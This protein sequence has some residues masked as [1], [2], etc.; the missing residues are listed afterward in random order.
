MPLFI[1][2]KNVFLPINDFQLIVFENAN[3]M[4]VD[5]FMLVDS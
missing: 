5:N 3:G 1:R 4:F 2:V